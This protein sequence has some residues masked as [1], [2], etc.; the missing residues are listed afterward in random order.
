MSSAKLFGWIVASLSLIA[1]ANCIE[2]TPCPAEAKFGK[3][4][5]ISVTNCHANDTKCPFQ[6]GKNV[7]ME[8]TFETSEYR[9]LSAIYQENF[10]THFEIQHHLMLKHSLLA[11]SS[12]L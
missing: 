9:R 2:F 12:R 4:N 10:S 8:L 11:N 7:A 3:L 1:L 6:T 5:N